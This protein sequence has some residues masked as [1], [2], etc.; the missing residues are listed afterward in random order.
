MLMKKIKLFFTAILVLVTAGL[1]YA[2][3]LTVTGTVS[4]ADNGDP[5]PFAS[6]R[7]NG[8]M[9]GAAT[10]VDGTYTINVPSSN[11]VLVFSFVGYKTA[12]VPVNG[13]LVVNCALA[14]DATALDDVVVVAYGSAKKE[15]VTGSVTSVK[16]ETLASAP[17]TSVDKALSGKLA[18]VQITQSS[19]QPGAASQI[20]IRGNS[21]IN[22]SN[23]PLWVVDG[24]PI[25]SGGTS[26]MTNTSNGIATINPNDIE[27]IDV[28]KDASA[29]A[30]YGA[31]GANGVI[32]ITTKKGSAGKPTVT[33]NGS[34]S[35]SS[36]LNLPEMMSAYDF[37]SLQA[38][39]MSADEF[40][41]AYLGRYADDV[42]SE[43][44]VQFDPNH[45]YPTLE[46]YKNAKTYDWQKEIIRSP[47]S[48]DHHLSLSG[49]NNGTRYSAS[50]SY[51]D[52]QGVIIN[53]G[54]KRYRGR[55]SLQQKVNDKV[56]VDF[57][58]NYSQNVQ[59]G[60]TVSNST[61]APSS[62]YMYSV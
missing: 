24:I 1:A 56:T 43:S 29:T 60:Q 42:A 61:S 21:S 6:I 7:V 46:S 37:V 33:Y 55:F 9:I 25:V 54:M 45:P 53:S 59:D 41:K 31:R 13:Q 14:P 62:S 2:Q 58:T 26:E 39:L 34:V 4:D 27:S 44:G 49:N 38:E 17:V 3:S 50:L 5:I 28:L 36:A 40:E 18:G 23:T 51:S 30:I 10:G 8:T 16:G 57:N 35:V 47:V 32:I 12:E 19:G 20:R 15:A 22:A 48:H 11:S 52:K